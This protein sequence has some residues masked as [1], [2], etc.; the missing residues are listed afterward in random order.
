MM[1]AT[2][3]ANKHLV[4][5]WHNNNVGRVVCTFFPILHD[6]DEKRPS[7]TFSGGRELK[8]KIISFIF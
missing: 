3:T 4:L 7:F 8:T 2:R 1:T 6:Y 5:D